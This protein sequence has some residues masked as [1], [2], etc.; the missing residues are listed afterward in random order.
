[1]PA[2]TLSAGAW[3]EFSLHYHRPPPVIRYC[4]VE[5][6]ERNYKRKI[7]CLPLW[8]RRGRGI[9]RG[10]AVFSAWRSGGL[11]PTAKFELLAGVQRGIQRL[12]LSADVLDSLTKQA[13]SE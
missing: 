9:L 1:M 3:A 12:D 4:H 11:C 10:G 13:A 8:Q 7:L 6:I 5:L 2:V